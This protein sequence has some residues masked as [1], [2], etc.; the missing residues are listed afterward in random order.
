MNG[1]TALHACTACTSHSYNALDECHFLVS[2]DGYG[3]PSVLSRRHVKVL[4]LH[5][6]LTYPICEP[7]LVKGLEGLVE[8]GRENA[9][10]PCSLVPMPA[11]S[12]RSA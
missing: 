2:G 4:V 5:V 3:F 11:V 6:E 9:I 12:K 1:E 8:N 10:G 7:F